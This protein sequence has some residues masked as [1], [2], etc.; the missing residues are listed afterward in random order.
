MRPREL[1]PGASAALGCARKNVARF[2][3]HGTGRCP[4]RSV[5]SRSN[6]GAGKFVVIRKLPDSHM[7]HMH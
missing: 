6:A 5:N 4:M 7:A 1:P 3:A 2:H